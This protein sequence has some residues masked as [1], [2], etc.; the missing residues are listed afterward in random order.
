MQADGDTAPR[1]GFV[2]LGSMG[3]PIA[4]RLLAGGARLAVYDLRS[5]AMEVLVAQGA[6]A[7]SRPAD[8][9]SQCQF[10]FT[11]LPGP[12]ELADVYLGSGGICETLRPG[13]V[14]VDL[15]TADGETL[16]RVGAAVQAPGGHLLAA[17]VTN[18]VRNAQAGKLTLFV[19]GDPDALQRVTPWL[20]TFAA[21][22][23]YLG[24][25][26]TRASSAKLITNLLW[27]VHAAAVGEALCLALKCG[28]P[29]EKIE[30]I[31]VD[32]VADSWVARNDVP[33]IKAGHYDP[34]FT[35]ELC[36]KDLRL[37]RELAANHGVPLPVGERAEER[38]KL[39]RESFGPDGAELLVARLIES[40]AGVYFS[41]INDGG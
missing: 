32:S 11:S 23:H 20:D 2:G 6:D 26:L 18:G 37:V 39:A 41:E 13:T 3:G 14:C 15:T 12:L 22:A 4:E 33:S 40:A 25:D 36:C 17:P 30:Q 8:I 29:R 7:S 35:L 5:D 24:D 38:F 10:I 9:A 19:A 34:S 16:Q 21:K 28:I 27:F 31:L 1:I